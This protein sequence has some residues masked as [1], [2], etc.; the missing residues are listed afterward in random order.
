M[1]IQSENGDTCFVSQPQK[2]VEKYVL[3]IY[4]VL[5]SILLT[6]AIAVMVS[7][8]CYIVI[9]LC[10]RKKVTGHSSISKR[11]S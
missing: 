10:R 3:T 11:E 7:S 9:T 2:S 5:F 8:A 1:S 4:P 6:L